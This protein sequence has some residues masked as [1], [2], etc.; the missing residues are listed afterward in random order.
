[1]D[2]LL[3]SAFAVLEDGVVVVGCHAA[4]ITAHLEGSGATVIDNPAW[5][6][7]R[8]GGLALAATMFPGRDLCVAPV[9]C[10]LVPAKIFSTL[11]SSWNEAGCPALGWWAPHLV[12]TGGRRSFGHPILVGRDL[13]QVLMK[14][15][16]ETPLR[17]L[18]SRAE[19]LG[20]V[21]VRDVS[22]LDN[23]D[24]AE[25]LQRLKARVTDP[26]TGID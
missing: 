13:A 20:T 9:D 3:A 8:T 25:D 21:E 7:G 12:T 26:P 23:L 6:K 15:P 22:I 24:T 17:S 4:E 2:R 14:I 1:M 16:P 10:P 19:T 18:R 5:A 11:V